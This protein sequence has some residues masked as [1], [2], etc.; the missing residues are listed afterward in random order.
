[1]SDIQIHGLGSD[2]TMQTILLVGPAAKTRN[3][4]QALRS[5]AH[6]LCCDAIHQVPR[7]AEEQG[8]EVIIC[9]GLADSQLGVCLEGLGETFKVIVLSEDASTRAQ[10]DE[11][12]YFAASEEISSPDLA[13]LVVG[14]L[15]RGLDHEAKIDANMDPELIESVLDAVTPLAACRDL[16]AASMSIAAGLLGLLRADRIH[17]LYYDGEESLLWACTPATREHRATSG[18]AGFVARTGRAATVEHARLDPRYHAST[19]DPEG[20]GRERLLL[21]PVLAHARVHV[22]VVVVRGAHRPSFGAR[23]LG[24]LEL[25][26]ER[27]GP[28]VEQLALREH[29]KAL[30]RAREHAERGP[31]R[32]EAVRARKRV[33]RYGDVVRITPGWVGGTYWGLVALALAGS[34]YLV[35]AHVNLYSTGPAV[36]RLHQRTEVTAHASGAMAELVVDPG[37]RVERDQLLARLDDEQA[38]GELARVEAAWNTQLRARLLDPSDA[39]TAAAVVGLRRQLHEARAELAEREI[40]APEPGVV[41]DLRIRPGQHIAVGQVVLSLSS[42]ELSQRVIALMPGADSP[43]IEPGMIMRVELPGYRHAYRDLVVEHVDDEVIGPSEAQRFLGP[44]LADSIALTGPV[45]LIEARLPSAEF[46]VDG[47]SYRY[48]EGMQA[49]AEIRV[50]SESLLELL[51][52]G[53]QGVLPGD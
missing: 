9:V 40:R 41:G 21:S 28:M 7:I 11:R 45:V 5:I 48:H 26:C 44:A 20:D 6:S 27:A 33:L 16:A 36:V 35:F 23:E 22:V 24:I 51:I 18:V 3:L 49:T 32:I 4:A 12:V 47:I 53:L 15:A 52:P 34:L 39:A 30:V 38:R 37:Q 29:A 42:D 31:F 46:S 14:A 2:P 8:V 10:M 19:D 17:C 1:M 25:F 43:R 13:Q 50:R